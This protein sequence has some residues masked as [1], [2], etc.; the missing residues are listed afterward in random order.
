MYR[1]N[2]ID[3]KQINKVVPFTWFLITQLRGDLISW[4]T[5]AFDVKVIDHIF[6]PLRE[7]RED[8]MTLKLIAISTGPTRKTSSVN[9]LMK[10]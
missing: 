6:A 5:A 1:D 10:T 2:R 9:Q 4:E 3:E 8:A 7:S